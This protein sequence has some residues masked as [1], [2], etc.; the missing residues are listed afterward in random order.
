M[1][2]KISGTTIDLTRGDS[3]WSLIT[4]TRKRDGT[5]YIPEEGDSLRF[6]VKHN[7][8]DA[9]RKKYLNVKP[10]IEKAI[11][12]DTLILY[13]NPTDTK[14]LSF[15][16]YV[17]DIELTFSDGNVDTFINNAILNVVPEVD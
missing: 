10:L 15:G 7:A 11:P 6:V 2:Y 14:G 17:Y 8:M 5:P 4:M 1:S 16:Q 9:G 3:F 12:T 13:L